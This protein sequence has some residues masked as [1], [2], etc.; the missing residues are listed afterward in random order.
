M[1]FVL[2]YLAPNSADLALSITNKMPN[3]TRRTTKGS[4]RGTTNAGLCLIRVINDPSSDAS[5][6]DAS[7]GG[8]K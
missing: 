5:P 8:T 2:K 4:P 7:P 6:N 3:G 1:K